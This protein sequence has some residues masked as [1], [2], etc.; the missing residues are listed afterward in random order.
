M[1]VLWLLAVLLLGFPLLAISAIP[2]IPADF[3][4]AKQPQVCVRGSNNVL[5]VF[6]QSNTIFCTG[7][8]NGG[9]TFSKPIKVA[10]VDHLALGMRRG[11]RIVTTQSAQVISAISHVTGDLKLWR[12]NDGGHV[13]H[14]TVTV[15]DVPRAAREGLHAMAS[16][17][18]NRIF[19]VWLD[20]R[21][22]Q[23]ELWG[24]LSEDEGY[25]WGRNIRIYQSADGHICECCHPT[26]EFMPNGDL[27]VMWRN[28]LG[29][30]RDIFFSVSKD[31]RKFAEAHKLGHGK[32]PLKGCPMDGGGLGVRADGAFVSVW[33]RD[34]NI[35]S[36]GAEGTEKKV[37][38]GT[39]PIVFL[40]KDKL[41][42]AWQEGTKLMLRNDGD[43]ALSKL[44]TANGIYAAAAS[45]VPNGLA[46]VVWES[47]Q[48]T[49]ARIWAEVIE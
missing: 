16:D 8:T 37:G 46:I 24:A 35:L 29:G 49:G 47:T 11:P 38:I 31:G 28:W 23:T 1:R 44:L 41:M 20:L 33:R 2:V 48:D 9:R 14:Q 43:A 4:G 3:K 45:A 13:W 27:V 39:Q 42:Y 19:I 7:S 30:S 15:N 5:V 36:A 26:V 34:K 25:T 17:G 21:S 40:A 32:W 10:L 12:S 22:A 6:G 18:K